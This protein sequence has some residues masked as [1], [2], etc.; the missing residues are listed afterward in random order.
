MQSP[1]M[2]KNSKLKSENSE[3][4]KKNVELNEKLETLKKNVIELKNHLD[5]SVYNQI[6]LKNQKINDLSMQIQIGE[7]KMINLN[8]QLDNFSFIN[9]KYKG[10]KA[11]YYNFLKDKLKNENFYLTQEEIIKEL[12]DKNIQLTEQKNKLNSELEKNNE[13]FVNL[14]NNLEKNKK[15]ILELQND[16]SKKIEESKESVSILK[17][18]N[19]EITNLQT[20]L[21]LLKNEGEQ[22]LLKEQKLKKKLQKVNDANKHLN[23]FIQ[24]NSIN[25]NKNKTNN[26]NISNNYNTIADTS[27]DL[28]LKQL[29]KN[30]RN[31]FEPL[32]NSSNSDFKLNNNNYNDQ[33]NLNEFEQENMNELTGL[34][35]KI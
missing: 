2:I 8:K 23:S 6:E 32:N 7:E 25:I 3:L 1:T 4:K 35:K 31:Y 33:S 20:T 29:E 10:V 12:K 16:L 24:E 26:N 17:E 27:G 18:K 21:N 34:M 22:N 9:Q 14:Y 28:L 11:Q 30:Q 19:K 5:N 13:N 15:I